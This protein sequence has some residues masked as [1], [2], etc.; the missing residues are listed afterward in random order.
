[1]TASSLRS[2]LPLLVAA[3]IGAAC[4][5]PAP[6]AAQDIVRLTVRPPSVELAIDEVLVFTAEATLSNGNVVNVTELVE[7]RSSANSVAKVSNTRGSKGRVTA[8]GVGQASIAVKDPLTEISSGQSGG[9]AVVA[10]LG[11]LE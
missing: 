4:A 9:S 6:A 3:V 2:A 11:K 10:V 1:M 7:W 8:R 5:V